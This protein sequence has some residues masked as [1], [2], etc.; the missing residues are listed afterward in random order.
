[1]VDIA[2]HL[3]ARGR[4]ASRRRGKDDEADA[5]TIARVAFNA[6]R[7]CRDSPSLSSTPT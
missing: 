6:S 2:T 7:I 3:T 5:V 1:M 4:K